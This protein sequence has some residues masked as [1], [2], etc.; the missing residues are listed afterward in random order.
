[1]I[2]H[3]NLAPTMELDM[4]VAE[5]VT[6]TGA[7]VERAARDVAIGVGI[8]IQDEHA[9]D[10]ANAKTNAVII[11]NVSTLHQSV[12]HRVLMSD[13]TLVL[14]DNAGIACS[15][16]TI[17][18][19]K[20]AVHHCK[21]GLIVDIGDYMSLDRAM[22]WLASFPANLSLYIGGPDTSEAPGIYEPAYYFLE[23][24]MA[25]CRPVNVRLSVRGRQ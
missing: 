16:A 21:P 13:A 3:H 9:N 14:Y 12:E 23:D 25:S 18:A 4:P 8:A 24:L 15:P 1:M 11:E 6:G 19:Q 5:I 2:S 10:G 22:I 20:F 7:G 17:A